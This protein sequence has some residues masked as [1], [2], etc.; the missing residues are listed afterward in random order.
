MAGMMRIDK[1]FGIIKGLKPQDFRTIRDIL[2]QEGCPKSENLFS[3]KEL[4]VALDS[5]EEHL[6]VLHK[7]SKMSS[8]DLLVCIIGSKYILADA[9]FRSKSVKN[10]SRTEI[11]K[12]INGSKVII[13]S[14]YIYQGPFYILF[15][16][17]VLTNS[18]YNRLKKMFAYSPRY[19]FKN[20]INFYTLFEQ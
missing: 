20:T 2:A 19:E 3:D 10:I 8:A 17:N 11:D 14:D 9:K 15:R 16:A 18:G 7:K 5:I 6:G 12:K 4:G 13:N 1:P